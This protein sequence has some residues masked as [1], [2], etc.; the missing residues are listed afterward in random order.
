[1]FSSK[2]SSKSGS[3]I[4]VGLFFI[5][6]ITQDINYHDF[7]DKRHFYGIP[8]TL[9]IVS[10]IVIF[11][12]GILGV[13]FILQFKLKLGFTRAN[14]FFFSALIFTAV[15]SSYY[16]LNPTNETLIWDRLPMTMTFMAFFSVVI[17]EF[18]SKTH[19]YKLLFPLIALGFCSILYWQLTKQLG[20]EDLRFYVLVQFLP[21]ILIVLILT[22]YRK[23]QFSKTT[24]FI[25]LMYVLAKLFEEF[26]YQVFSILQC[27]SGHSIK[28]LFAG[29]APLFYLIYLLKQRKYQTAIKT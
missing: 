8:N 17:Y 4:A 11:L 5:N 7:A 25:V 26:D 22:M 2:I 10:N 27:V 15:G 12:V 1:M 24:W 21:I 19:S 20:K 9:N 18:I 14:L 13:L 28:H 29:I 16:H 6:P 3:E 23:N